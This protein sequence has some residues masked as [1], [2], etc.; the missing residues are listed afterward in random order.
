M[1]SWLEKDAQLA[2]QYK[3]ALVGI[4]DRLGAE[5]SPEV[6]QAV[7]DVLSMVKLD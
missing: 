5:G 1:T 2:G 3:T 7:A 4:A 6:I